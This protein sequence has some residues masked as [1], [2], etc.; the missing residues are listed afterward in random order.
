MYLKTLEEQLKLYTK[1][2][3][4]NYLLAKILLAMY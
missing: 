3:K 4:A 2:Q 1:E